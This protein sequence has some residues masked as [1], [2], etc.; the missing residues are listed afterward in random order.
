MI[1]TERSRGITHIEDLPPLEFIQTVKE[2]GI[3]YE[4]TEKLDGSQILFG[5][6]ELGF[7]TSRESKGGKRHYSATEYDI[8]FS[9]TYR[10]SV[11][12]LLESI[13]PTLKEIGLSV[14]DQIECE[15]LFGELPNVVP[16]SPDTNYL[17]F[18]RSTAGLVDINKLQNSLADK[19]ISTV[20]DVPYT[21]DGIT[22]S[23]RTEMHDWKFKRSPVITLSNEIYTKVRHLLDKLEYFLHAGTMYDGVSRLD[24]YSLKMNKCPEFISHSDWSTEKLD[25]TNEREI[26]RQQVMD[27]KLVIKEI[28]LQYIVHNRPSAFGPIC[29]EGGWIEGVVFRHKT[30]GN[31]LKLVDKNVFGVM[32]QRAWKTRNS[33]NERSMSAQNPASIMGKLDVGLAF[34]LGHPEL[35]TIQ[36]RPYLKRLNIPI[37]DIIS[38]INEYM[39]FES[40]KSY[41]FHLADEASYELSG[42]LASYKD[43]TDTGEIRRRTLETFAETFIRIND[44][45]YKIEKSTVP[46]DL[47]ETVAGKYLIES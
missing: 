34:A 41:L 47:L 20:L 16:Y 31:M 45:K 36:A 6:D 40:I 43:H 13:L 26:L 1:L 46:S 8:Q 27:M 25:I 9:T 17:I 11:H 33:I 35:G 19:Y 2:L 29:E 32:R 38:S 42:L 23:I 24:I 15:V 5:M 39:E 21:D 12:L 28:L 14:G 18:L 30:T 4:T 22:M 3:S 44:T 37:K 10:R 7:Y